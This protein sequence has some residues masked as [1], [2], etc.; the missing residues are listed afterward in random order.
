MNYASFFKRTAAYLIDYMIC[1][2]LSYVLGFVIGFP[3]GVWAG[4]RHIT[5]N[6]FI[7]VALGLCAG[8]LSVIL[9]F[10]WPESSP[11]QATL[12]KKLFGLQVTDMNG[13]R[14]SFWR[15]LGRNFGILISAFTFC[16]GYL[17]CL[18]TKKKQCLHD[19]MA[20]CLVVDTIPEKRQGL[21]IGVTIG[22]FALYI[23][24][25]FGILAA[26]LLPQFAKANFVGQANNALVLLNTTEQAQEIYYMQHGE[27]TT[28]WNQLELDSCKHAVGNICVVNNLQ[29][30]LKDD[31]VSVS[32]KNHTFKLTT[33][34]GADEMQCESSASGAFDV[35]AL[36]AQAAEKD[37]E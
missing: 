24:A 35:C 1:S 33:Q 36:L 26:L 3:I 15:S 7:P 16:I 9:Y 31:T 34:Y 19:K 25:V 14:I 13:K 12:G 5:L 37:E 20:G 2:P 29:L 8:L 21:A 32:P 10:V 18:W 30:E 6:P 23:L 28:Q 17:M 22:V 4:V 11:W 27:Y